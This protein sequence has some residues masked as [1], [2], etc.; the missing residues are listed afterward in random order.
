[1][2]LNIHDKKLDFTKFQKNSSI[3]QALKHNSPI[4]YYFSS[5]Y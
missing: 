1:M 3:I 2:P 5:R 4:P